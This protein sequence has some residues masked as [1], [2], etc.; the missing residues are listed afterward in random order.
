MN[1]LRDEVTC[2]RKQVRGI[3]HQGHVG[4]VAGLLI[5]Y[6]RRTCKCVVCS[7]GVFRAPSGRFGIVC[8]ICGRGS[9]IKLVDHFRLKAKSRID[10]VNKNMAPV[11]MFSGQSRPEETRRGLS[12]RELAAMLKS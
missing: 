1:E 6:I 3:P 12:A 10:K 8:E 5:H 2:S 9:S 11:R 7:A 4:S